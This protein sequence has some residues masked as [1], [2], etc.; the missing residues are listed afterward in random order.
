ME[1]SVCQLFVCE[2]PTLQAP[3]H[4]FPLMIRQ[5]EKSALHWPLILNGLFYL[6]IGNTLQ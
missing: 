5:L 2:K 1:R 3:F 4:T 6:N